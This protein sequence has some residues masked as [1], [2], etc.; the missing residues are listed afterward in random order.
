MKPKLRHIWWVKWRQVARDSTRSVKR[1]N[2]SACWKQRQNGCPYPVTSRISFWFVI[3]DVKNL[4][5][6]LLHASSFIP[7][8][9]V[10]KHPNFSMNQPECI[11]VVLSRFG[12]RNVHRLTGTLDKYMETI[13]TVHVCLTVKCGIS[14]AHM[15][16][17]KVAAK[18]R[19]HQVWYTVTDETDQMYS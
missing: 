8:C 7:I 4:T 13:L 5:W 16:S 3:K 19:K 10:K 17:V 9:F 12:R 2:Y 15:N 1:R 11:S 14:A 18:W 6:E